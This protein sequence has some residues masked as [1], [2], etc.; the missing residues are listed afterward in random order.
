MSPNMSF[1]AYR[2]H[3]LSLPALLHNIEYSGVCFSNKQAA[4]LPH[5]STSARSGSHA[6]QLRVPVK[7]AHRE[8]CLD[9]SSVMPFAWLIH[10][11]EVLGKQMKRRLQDRT[12]AVG[13][14]YISI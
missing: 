13:C 6:V 2:T 4:P 5:S 8:S 7:P 10:F 11:D 1:K 14:S 9:A 3:N 12:W